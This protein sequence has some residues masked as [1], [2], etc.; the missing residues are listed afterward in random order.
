MLSTWYFQLGC[1]KLSRISFQRFGMY[2]TF[3]SP[4]PHHCIRTAL[5]RSTVFQYITLREICV[6]IVRR[7]LGEGAA[8]QIAVNTIES[9]DRTKGNIVYKQFIVGRTF[10]QIE[11]QE[12]LRLHA[13]SIF[14]CTGLNGTIARHDTSSSIIIIG[15]FFSSVIVWPIWWWIRRCCSTWWGSETHIGL[16]EKTQQKLVKTKE[17]REKKTN[18]TKKFGAEKKKKTV[19]A[20]TRNQSHRSSIVQ[21]FFLLFFIFKWTKTA[22]KYP[23]CHNWGRPDSVIVVLRHREKILREWKIPNNNNNSKLKKKR[24]K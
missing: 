5:I 7:I 19:T 16:C 23:L 1:F 24:I 17:R 10:A 12:K 15:I 22:I 20:T 8:I 14:N 21:Q 3:W 9:V 6:H 18:K 2:S 13:L 4:N 11:I